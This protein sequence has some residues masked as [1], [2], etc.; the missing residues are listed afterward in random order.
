MIFHVPYTIFTAFSF[1]TY[2]SKIK[3]TSLL[4]AYFQELATIF[5][6]YVPFIFTPFK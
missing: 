1:L 4:A 5:F 3:H 6:L 2:L